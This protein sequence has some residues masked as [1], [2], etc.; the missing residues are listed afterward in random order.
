MDV[1][2]GRLREARLYLRYAIAPFRPGTQLPTFEK[3]AELKW[4]IKS[5]LE[6]P[7]LDL[8]IAE[9]HRQVDRQVANLESLRGRSSALLTL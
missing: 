4:P 7:D 8:I 3:P 1:V 5:D 2:T 6:T 9:A